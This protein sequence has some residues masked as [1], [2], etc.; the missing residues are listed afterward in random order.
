MACFVFVT[1]DV[2]HREGIT[3]APEV[4]DTLLKECFWAFS[5]SAPV[6]ERLDAGDRA[7]VYV[8]GKGR[9]HFV[10]SCVLQDRLSDATDHERAVLSSLG[11]GFMKRVIHLGA[12]VRFGAPVRIQPLLNELAFIGDKKNYGLSLRLP[13]REID[14]AEFSLIVAKQAV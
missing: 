13:V 14:P 3:P 5:D 1:M 4:V 12:V 9:H 7:A 10:A 8:G 2:P 6:K 11:L